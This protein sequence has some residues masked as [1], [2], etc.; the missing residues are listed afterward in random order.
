M[1]KLIIAG[2]WA[3]AIALSSLYAV[4]AMN[5]VSSLERRLKEAGVLETTE[6]AR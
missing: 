1:V 5:T 6:D 2:V 3:L 4:V